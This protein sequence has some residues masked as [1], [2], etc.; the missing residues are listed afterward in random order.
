MSVKTE[1]MKQTGLVS[2]QEYIKESKETDLKMKRMEIDSTISNIFRDFAMS[3]RNLKHIF[4][5]SYP[6]PRE[7]DVQSTAAR[8]KAIDELREEYYKKVIAKY[9]EMKTFID[10]A[11]GK[12]TEVEVKDDDYEGEEDEE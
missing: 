6:Y 10:D 8:L 5:D 9:G 3:V 11:F 12:T 1:L 2:R 7:D 4:N